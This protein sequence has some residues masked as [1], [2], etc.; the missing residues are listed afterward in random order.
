MNN[1]IPMYRRTSHSAFTHKELS[2]S[3]AKTAFKEEMLPAFSLIMVVN[4]FGISFM[5]Y[6]NVLSYFE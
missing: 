2:N 5:Y 3:I 4:T 1:L 6:E